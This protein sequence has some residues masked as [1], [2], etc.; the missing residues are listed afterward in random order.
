MRGHWRETQGLHPL[1]QVQYADLMTYLPGDIL[2]KVDRASMAHA[3]EVRVPALDHVLVEW[4]ATLP[5]GSAEC[6]RQQVR[7]EDRA[8]SVSAF[9]DTTAP[10]RWASRCRSRRGCA[11]RCSPCRARSGRAGV[12]RSWTVRSGRRQPPDRAAPERSQRSRPADL[13]L[14]MF[15]GFL[16]RVHEREAARLTGE[17]PSGARVQAPEPAPAPSGGLAEG[18]SRS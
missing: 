18:S 10:W 6:T 3:L 12:R 5:P 9:C 7:A 15:A 17:A 13:G 16:T 4:A 8:R 2:T 11:V 1:D 14:F